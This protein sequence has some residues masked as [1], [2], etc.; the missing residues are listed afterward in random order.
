M[1]NLSFSTCLLL[2]NIDR[3]AVTTSING[4]QIGVNFR[5]DYIL[6]IIK[7]IKK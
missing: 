1:H 4:Y 3:D 5:W 6:H 7:V 2:N